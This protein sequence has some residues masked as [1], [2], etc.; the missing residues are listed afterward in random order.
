MNP[1]VITGRMRLYIKTLK[2]EKDLL[3]FS[4]HK[5][6][7]LRRKIRK[8]KNIIVKMA[9]LYLVKASRIDIRVVGRMDI[10]IFG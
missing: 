7:G 6:P 5:I 1:V 10:V 3:S 2:G 8:V 9:M 4:D